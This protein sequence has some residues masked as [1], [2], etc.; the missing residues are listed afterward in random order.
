MP[1]PWSAGEILLNTEL[2]SA[3]PTAIGEEGPD[4][5]GPTSGGT[6]LT[7]NS[8]TFVQPQTAG[9]VQ[10]WGMMTFSKTV[11]TDTFEARLFIDGV[12]HGVARESGGTST[13]S[14]LNTVGSVTVDASGTVNV[15]QQI[16]R[17]AG[18]G[19]ATVQSASNCTLN[20]LF[21]PVTG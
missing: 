5:A 18:T 10:A 7:V 19:T 12:Q 8:I 20:A 1:F 3:I 11:G 4:S 9:R 16:L 21:I 13:L 15:A 17:V 2:N 6:A 14:T